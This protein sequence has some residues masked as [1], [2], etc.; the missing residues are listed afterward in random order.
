M[1]S[2][3]SFFAQLIYFFFFL[4]GIISAQNITAEWGV[5]PKQDL[6]MKTFPEDT[7]AAAVF[8]Y[9]NGISKFNDE[10]NIEYDRHTRIKILTEKGYEWGTHSVDLYKMGSEELIKDIEGTTYWI[11]GNGQVEKKE[12]SS[13]DIIEE[14][15]NKTYTRV[16]F[17]LPALKPGCIVEF[18]YKIISDNLYLMRN[19]IFQRSEP[20]RWSEYRI[21]APK[22]IAYALVFQGLEPYEINEVNDTEQFFSGTAVSYF[23]KNTVNCN[24]HHY[25]VKDVPALRDEPFLATTWDYLNR[26]DVQLSGYA[27]PE[28]GKKQILNSWNSVVDELLDDKQFCGRIDETSKVSELVAEITKNCTSPL[29]KLKAIYNWVSSTIIVRSENSLFAQNKVNDII[30]NKKGSNAEIT[31]LLI[32]MLKSAG[33]NSVPVILSTREH[34][35]IQASYPIVS[36]FNYVLAMATLDSAKY[37]LDATD[38]LRPWD[39]LPTKVLNVR[40]I[41]IIP[42]T[43]GWLTINTDKSNIHKTL[44]NITLSADGSIKGNVEDQYSEYGALSVRKKIKDK[45]E[46]DIPKELLES[47]AM[48]Y[49]VDSYKIYGKDSIDLPLKLCAEISSPAYA[50]AN[51]DI[52]YIN[53]HMFQRQ[54]DNPFKT[55]SRKF[56]IDFSYRRS[57]T[58]FTTITIPDSF[59]IKE[60]IKDV[61]FSAAYKGLAFS[62]QVQTDSSKITVMTKFDIKDIEINPRFYEQVRDFYSRIAGIE[63]EQIV[64]EK[65]KPIIQVQA[66]SAVPQESQPAAAKQDKKDNRKK[67][68]K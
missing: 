31:F 66:A 25:A 8:L 14:E 48:G 39:I 40:G 13:K 4:A 27:F 36:Q 35:K 11:N 10:L 12:L 20:V 29:D 19:W 52:I 28:G 32:S 30:E 7:N 54:K 62:R 17:T 45:K 1:T 42:K 22:S 55:K 58:T 15:I 67:G 57:S 46:A 56:P 44:A 50:Q 41:N 26:L 63:A 21:I 34:G 61:S 65:R 18:K 59:V 68:K 24:D 6:E 37:F 38:P 47:E 3:K 33:I 64:F 9:D 60:T 43:F 49:S 23:G 16:K 53:P 5:I 2:R 51:G